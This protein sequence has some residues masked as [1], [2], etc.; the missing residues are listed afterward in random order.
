MI[1]ALILA[2]EITKGM[3]SFGSKSLLEIKKKISIIE[4][5]ISAL[6]DIDKNISITTAIG[7]ES[8]KILPVLDKHGVKHTYNPE[9]KNT[10]QS[11]SL[12]IFLEDN[13][14][15][16]NL[17]IIN[18]GILFKKKTITKNMLSGVSKIFVLDKMK[19]NFSLGCS[20]QEKIEYIFYDLPELWSECV[21]LNL[22][23]IDTIKYAILHNQV[24]QMYLFELINKAINLEQTFQKE[25]INK[26]NIMKI[27]TYKDINK[28]KLFI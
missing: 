11:Y 6:K 5:Q 17:L 16:D 19:E 9:Y 7:F 20:Q 18:N 15:I 13:P 1:N 22:E 8:E 10:N 27:N 14:S 12:K 4:Y 21:Y 3:K 23:A 25:H 26:K 28:A 24:N 2:P